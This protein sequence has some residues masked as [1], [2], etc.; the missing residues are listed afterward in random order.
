M[1]WDNLNQLTRLKVKYIYKY[2]FRV[3][4]C[5]IYQGA[6]LLSLSFNISYTSKRCN[7]RILVD[8]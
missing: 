5:N 4:M 2:L 8:A 3:G 1:N 6:D 7:P